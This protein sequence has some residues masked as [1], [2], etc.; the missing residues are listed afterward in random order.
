[1][2]TCERRVG[3]L[4][5]DGWSGD[6]RDLTMSAWAEDGDVGARGTGP[7]GRAGGWFN[8]RHCQ[9]EHGLLVWL[10]LRALAA[11][12]PPLGIVYAHEL[13]ALVGGEQAQETG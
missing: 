12:T 13:A 4:W 3:A 2:T 5:P 11:R 10:R 8:L 1:M 9:P 6:L 7:R